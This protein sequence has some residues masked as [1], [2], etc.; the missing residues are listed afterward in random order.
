MAT[1]RLCDGAGV[2]GIDGNRCDECNGTGLARQRVHLPRWISEQPP[3]WLYTVGTLGA[4][5]AVLAGF[6]IGW[7]AGR[8]DQSA[9]DQTPKTDLFMPV[10]NSAIGLPSQRGN[11]GFFKS[12]AT[13]RS[14]DANAETST[15]GY[16]GK[17]ES[18]FLNRRLEESRKSP[19]ETGSSLNLT[20]DTAEL[21]NP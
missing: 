15:Q 2:H 10:D 18:D 1:C 19:R 11:D 8:D 5:L 6:G 14:T 9:Q 16:G 3:A 21:L 20:P 12:E 4:L 7:L 17:D 13:P